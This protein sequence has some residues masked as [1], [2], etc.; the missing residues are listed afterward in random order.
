MLSFDIDIPKYRWHVVC[1]VA[2]SH[3]NH[4][5]IIDSLLDIYASDNVIEMASRNIMAKKLDTGFTYSNRRKRCSVMVIG[6]ASSAKEE[7][8]S[9]VHEIRHLVDDI[10]STCNLVPCGEDVAYLSGDLAMIMYEKTKN[11][12]CCKCHH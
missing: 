4:N 12:F 9:I 3:Y 11:L 6:L 10:S 1:F 5:E 8:N 2:V 7:M